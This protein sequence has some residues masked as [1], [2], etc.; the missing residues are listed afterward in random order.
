MDLS[1]NQYDQI[2]KYYQKGEY[3][4]VDRIIALGDIHGD[5]SAF[6]NCLR[7]STL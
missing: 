1:Q 6:K 7:M 4:N 2:F 3:N 5:L